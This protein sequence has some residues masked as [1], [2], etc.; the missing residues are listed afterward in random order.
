LKAVV[1]RGSRTAEKTLHSSQGQQQAV[2]DP[3]EGSGAQQRDGESHS[4]TEPSAEGIAA[5]HRVTLAVPVIW[6]VR[7]RLHQLGRTLLAL[8]GHIQVIAGQTVDL[9]NPLTLQARYATWAC[10]CFT[11][12]HRPPTP[13]R[14][15]LGHAKPSEEIDGTAANQWQPALTMKP[16]GTV[17]FRIAGGQTHPVGSGQAPPGD[18]RFDASKRQPHT[19]PSSAT[20]AR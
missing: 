6:Q 8:E 17:T 1:T 2:Q 19:W 11:S 4:S 9:V 5:L 18:E 12:D 20:L 7:G 3:H 16:G 15:R 14:R 10:H 13:R